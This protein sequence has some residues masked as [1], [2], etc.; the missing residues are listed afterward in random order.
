MNN[1]KIFFALMALTAAVGVS[2]GIKSK[3]R[4]KPYSSGETLKQAWEYKKAINN[5]LTEECLRNFSDFAS[6]LNEYYGITAKCCDCNTI[7]YSS[8]KYIGVLTSNDVIRTQG[9]AEIRLECMSDL[10]DYF[11]FNRTDTT[12]HLPE[13]YSP[14]YYGNH[15]HR[16]EPV[17]LNRRNLSIS[18]NHLLYKFWDL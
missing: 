11:L 7:E 1:K 10:E 6:A 2:A 8:G 18:T 9:N 12:G 16:G 15:L 14:F 17:M 13:H 3:R 5:V 4:K